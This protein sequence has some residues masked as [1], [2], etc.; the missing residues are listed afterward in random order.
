M[1]NILC[2]QVN[3]IIII[4]IFREFTCCLKVNNDAVFVTDSFYLSILDC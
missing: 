3:A 4:T 1:N 2:N